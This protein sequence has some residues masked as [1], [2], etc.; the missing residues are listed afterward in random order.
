MVFTQ[1]A[2]AAVETFMSS[3]TENFMNL[4]DQKHLKTLVMLVLWLVVTLF[5]GMWLWNNVAVKVITVL[6]PLTSIWQLLGLALLVDLI[7]P[8]CC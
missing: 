2:K 4:D 5:V 6:K 3:D 8:A 7:R 1:C